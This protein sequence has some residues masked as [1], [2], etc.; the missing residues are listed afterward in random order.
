MKST[1]LSLRGRL[2]VALPLEGA[3]QAPYLA[4][5]IAEGR[6]CAK[7]IDEYLMGSTEL[8]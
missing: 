6:E 5:A 8:P 7:A 4:W 3:T 2:H 1:K